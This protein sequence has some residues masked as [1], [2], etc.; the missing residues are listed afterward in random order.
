MKKLFLPLAFIAVMGMQAQ[1]KIYETELNEKKPVV[2]YNYLPKSNRIII[3]EAF[4][5]QLAYATFNNAI[6][7]DNKSESKQIIDNQ[8]F[9]YLFTSF[10]ELDY[11]S[12]F[13]NSAVGA[14]N[15]S[16]YQDN[17][18]NSFKIDSKDYS[19][20]SFNFEANK[21]EMKPR[22]NF[23]ENF[24]YVITD[25]KGKSSGLKIEKDILQLEKFDIEK[26]TKKSFKIKQIDISKLNSKDLEV[27][28]QISF[29]SRFYDDSFEIVTKT[30][31]DDFTSS[32]LYRHIYDLN[33]EFLKE[34]KYSY[35]SL[36]GVF[37]PI[38]TNSRYENLV[39]ASQSVDLAVPIELD[40]ND[41]LIDS[42]TN[43]LYVYGLTQDKKSN[44]Y[45]LNS[46]LGFYIIKFNENGD[47]IWEKYYDIIDV[48]GF[49]NK[50]QKPLTININ[51]KEYLNSNELVL[52]IVGLNTYTNHYN[53]FHVINKET[54]TVK[55]NKQINTDTKSSKGTFTYGGKYSI[56]ENIEFDKTKFCDETTFL[57]A[58]LNNEINNYIKNISKNKNDIFFNSIISKEGIWLI[59]TD[60]ETYYKV[61][62]FKS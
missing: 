41:Y 47:K 57:V 60:N 32:I 10:N 24:M 34:V 59:E 40:V 6:I 2:K 8:P 51:L 56:F 46:L 21:L 54:G 42:I 26:K 33:G 23:D 27:S 48:K 49:S 58:T 9:L 31:K 30:V 36:K 28:K 45:F 38:S 16:F 5:K 18:V 20:Y 3:K 35:N 25:Q 29:Q 39:N 11:G 52:S 50:K 53:I 62:F 4:E 55:M 22:I 14:L 43:D 12:L 61:N 15:I 37:A 13:T 44:S 19:K 17:K 7:F 1:T